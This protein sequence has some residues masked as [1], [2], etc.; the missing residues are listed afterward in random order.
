[1]PAQQGHNLFGPQ[2][3]LSVSVQG[4]NSRASLATFSTYPYGNHKKSSKPVP[5]QVCKW[6]I[7]AKDNLLASTLR[8]TRW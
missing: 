1:M 2:S 7:R 4:K 5:G 8:L 3:A 6:Q